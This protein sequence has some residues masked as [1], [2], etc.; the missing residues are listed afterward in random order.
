MDYCSL[1]VVAEKVIAH[2]TEQTSQYYL[3]DGDSTEK[4]SCLLLNK[5]QQDT[6]HSLVSD[7]TV[8]IIVFVITHVAKYGSLHSLV[9]TSH[10]ATY[11]FHYYCS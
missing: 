4:P 5:Q 7:S 9:T 1:P 2:V 11:T 10:M 8:R 6:I 3:D